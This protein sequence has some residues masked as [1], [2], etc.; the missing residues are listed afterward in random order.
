MVLE[1]KIQVVI[2]SGMRDNVR[3]GMLFSSDTVYM[4]NILNNI[5]IGCFIYHA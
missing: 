1:K 2:T 3:Q 4:N 5:A